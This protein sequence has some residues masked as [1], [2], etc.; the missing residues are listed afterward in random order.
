MVNKV[1]YMSM[2]VDYDLWAMWDPEK[3]VG[4]RPRPSDPYKN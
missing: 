1:V 3:A 2:V 4:H